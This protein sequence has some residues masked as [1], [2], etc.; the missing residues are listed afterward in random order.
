MFL[1]NYIL[2]LGIFAGNATEVDAVFLL[3]HNVRRHI[4]LICSTT[5]NVKCDHFVN[6]MP[7]LCLQ[8]KITTFPFISILWGDTLNP[9]KYSIFILLFLTILVSL[10]EQLIIG[11]LVSKLQT[12][13]S[14]MLSIRSFSSLH[15]YFTSIWPHTYL[16]YSMNYICH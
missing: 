5:S 12:Y 14:I 7:A 8:C 4:V 3:V 2:K 13:I 16:F 1:N 10:F 15:L 9:C 6:L 11:L